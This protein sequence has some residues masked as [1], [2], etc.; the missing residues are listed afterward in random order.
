MSDNKITNR[1]GSRPGAGRPTK[2]QQQARATEAE[3][4]TAK[5]DVIAAPIIVKDSEGKKVKLNVV[6]EIA[7]IYLELSTKSLSKEERAELRDRV[8]ILRELLPYSTSKK[9]IESLQDNNEKNSVIK[10]SDAQGSDDGGI[11]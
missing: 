7:K 3:K 6:E 4:N 8:A 5:A 9:P 10:I 1:G 11:V 2:A